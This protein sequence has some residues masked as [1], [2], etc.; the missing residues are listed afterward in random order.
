M[1][2]EAF[3]S[4]SIFRFH[5]L[6]SQWGGGEVGAP[7]T[8]QKVCLGFKAVMLSRSPHFSPTQGLLLVENSSFALS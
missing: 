7:P 4:V 2:G 6:G 5:F 3:T 1:K 8:L